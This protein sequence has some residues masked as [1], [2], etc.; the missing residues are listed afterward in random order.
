MVEWRSMTERQQTMLIAL[1]GPLVGLVAVIVLRPEYFRL[2]FPLDDAWIHAVYARSL[3]EEGSYAYNP[4]EPATGATSMLWPLLLAVVH[5]ASASTE[6]FVVGA[7]LLG[8]VLH[9]FATGFAAIALRRAGD[10]WLTLAISA[11][12]GMNP[13][14]LAASL[15]GMEVSLATLVAAAALWAVRAERDRALVVVAFFAYPARPELALLMPILPIAA[16]APSDWR[17]AMRDALHALAGVALSATLICVRAWVVSGRPLPAT[18]YAKV[19]RSGV[20]ASQAL[21]HGFTALFDELSILRFEWV[22]LPLLVVSLSIVVRPSARE[23]IA[24]AA[25]LCGTLGCAVSFVLAP[26]DDPTA[27]Y[28]QRYALPFTFCMLIAVAPLWRAALEPLS[29]RYRG[30]VFALPL[31]A[32]VLLA[33]VDTP[34]RIAHLTNDAHNI[35][36]VQ[37]RIGK[38]LADVP[39]TF[40]TWT[41]DAGAVRYFASGYVVDVVGL[42]TAA[43]LE[44]EPDAYVAEHSPHALVLFK[45]WALGF[46]Q[47]TEYSTTTPYSITS[48]PAMGTQVL[49]RCIPGTRVTLRGRGLDFRCAGGVER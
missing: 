11:L 7:K 1:L 12:A 10:R 5:A 38:T 43:M 42:N 32:L 13:D 45:G 36:D 15:S 28:Y 9:A 25:F 20:T 40:T 4:G 37:V 46:G 19:G 3:M 18:F 24:A 29:A 31:S 27:F 44:H 2:G 48:N 35:D 16:R 33:G 34:F 30:L 26:A 47:H 8:F 49:T 14:L 17:A 23:R 6:A 21:V 41:V 22:W 39:D